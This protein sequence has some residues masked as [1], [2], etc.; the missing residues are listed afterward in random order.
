GGLDELDAPDQHE[1]VGGEHAKL[2]K[3]AER[4][5]GR[6]MQKRRQHADADVQVLAVANDR[7]EEGEHDH[8]QHRHRLWPGGGAVERIAGEHAVGDD[9][10][11]DDEAGSGHEQTGGVDRVH[12]PD[13]LSVHASPMLSSPA[14]IPAYAG[15]SGDPGVHR[16]WGGAVAPSGHMERSVVTGSRLRGDDD[17]RYSTSWMRLISAACWAPYLSQTGLTASTNGFL[18]GTSTISAPASCMCLIDFCSISYQSL[19]CSCC[20]SLPDLR[21]SA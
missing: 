11:D 5:L 1:Q 9:E 7:R 8:Q 15:T 6:P 20:A 13:V 2:E 17:H 3:P 4:R 21:I 18:S 19:R 16:R 10:G 12:R 14:Q